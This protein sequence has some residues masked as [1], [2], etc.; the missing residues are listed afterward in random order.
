MSGPYLSGQA[1]CLCCDSTAIEPYEYY[2]RTGVS[3]LGTVEYRAEEG[4][5]CIDCGAIEDCAVVVPELDELDEMLAYY[6]D[7]PL[8]EPPA[9]SEPERPVRKPAARQTQPL[10]G[11]ELEVARLV[12]TG[13]R[14]K[15][16]AAELGISEI[17]VKNHVGRIL[18]KLNAQSRMDVML[19]VLSKSKQGVA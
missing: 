4:V 12:S 19:W 2:G 5:R 11:R 13:A 8:G 16:I 18:A 3:F 7:A 14:N 6:A 17:T 9:G 10:T 15:A 1:R